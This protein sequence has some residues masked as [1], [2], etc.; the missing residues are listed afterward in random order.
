MKSNFGWNMAFVYHDR[1]Y[2]HREV[3]QL[4]IDDFFSNP[5]F[6]T[7]GEFS[8]SAQYHFVPFCNNCPG[9]ISLTMEA[10]CRILSTNNLFPCEIK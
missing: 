6:F 2:F 1:E 9:I 5:V 4:R 3:K 10:P 8:S 7:N